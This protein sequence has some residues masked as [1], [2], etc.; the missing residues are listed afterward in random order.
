MIIGDFREEYKRYRALGTKAMAQVGDEALNHLPFPDG[1]SIA[2]IVRHVSGNL[3]SRFTDLL[4]ADGEKPNRNRDGEFADSAYTRAEVEAAWALG[5]DI[6]D[7]ELAKLSDTDAGRTVSIRGVELTVHEALCRSIAHAASHVG[8]IVLIAR[9]LAAHSW[10]TLSIPRGQS[11]AFN[12]D[13]MN[14]RLARG[15]A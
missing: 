8:Q 12:S 3:V 2:V 13:P 15:K 5:F 9:M 6:V 1:N 11:K 14:E 7:R 10:Q 4:T